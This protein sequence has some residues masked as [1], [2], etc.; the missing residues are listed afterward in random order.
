MDILNRVSDY[1]LQTNCLTLIEEK[2]YCYGP[3]DIFAY[4]SYIAD[5]F[6]TPTL[7]LSFIGSFPGVIF[8]PERAALKVPSAPCLSNLY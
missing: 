4:I 7:R 8:A 6:D 3:Y 1:S 5:M 2:H